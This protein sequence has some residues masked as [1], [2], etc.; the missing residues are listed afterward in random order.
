MVAYIT[1][2]KCHWFLLVGYFVSRNVLGYKHFDWAYENT[3]IQI[4]IIVNISCWHDKRTQTMM[5]E[6]TTP[7]QCNWTLHPYYISIL[8]AV[9]TIHMNVRIYMIALI[10]RASFLILPLA[11][12]YYWASA[13]SQSEGYV[14]T[15]RRGYVIWRI[16]KE[17]K[18]HKY[19]RFQ[20]TFPG[21]IYRLL[22][23]CNSLFHDNGIG[24][25]RQELLD[26]T[27]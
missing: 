9:M 10:I 24:F 11:K 26:S 14:M 16:R 18:F 12:F 13:N 3:R 4:I 2:L 8:T 7:M 27:N 5:K 25:C 21:F 19:T 1:G 20:A 6:L 23:A 22:A 15:Y 17:Q